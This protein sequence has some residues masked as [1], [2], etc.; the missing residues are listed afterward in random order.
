MKQLVAGAALLIVIV[1]GSLAYRSIAEKPYRL[2]IATAC[3]TEAMICPD[4][5]SVGRTGPDCSFAR[6]SSGAVSFPEAG[7]TFTLPEGY[8]KGVQEPGADGDAEGML[9]FFQKPASGG[10]HYVSIYRYPIPADK[11]ADEVILENARYQPADMQAADFSRFVTKSIGDKTFRSTVIERFEGQVDS[12]YF[13]AHT[14]DVL[15]FDILEKGVDWTNPDLQIETLPEH[16]AL[17][18]MLA[19]LVVR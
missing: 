17:L 11:T 16:Q 19:T 10:N 3:T 18:Q 8:V 5:S 12:A 7:I 1:A 15:R 9:D 4:G 6:C 2:D 13:L 14:N